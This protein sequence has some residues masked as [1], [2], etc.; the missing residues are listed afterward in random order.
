[1]QND[2]MSFLELLFKTK[3]GK[4]KKAKSGFCNDIFKSTGSKK[5]KEEDDLYDL[6]NRCSECGEEYELCECSNC[7]DKDCQMENGEIITS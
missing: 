1:M 7:R 4:N 3:K 5:K 2:N 6:M